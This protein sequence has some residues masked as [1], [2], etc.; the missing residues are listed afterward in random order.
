M[1]RKNR[2]TRGAL[3]ASLLQSCAIIALLATSVDA[4]QKNKKDAVNASPAAA[5][6]LTRTTTK[7]ESRRFGYGSALTL[8]GAP[9]GSIT[10][11]SWTRSEV[12]ITADIEL[13]ADSEEDLTLLSTV[14]GFVL[15]DDVNRVRILTTG[16][17][18]KAFMKR[19]AKGFPKRLLGLPWK[20]DYRIRVPAV[21]DIEIDAG[22]GPITLKGVEGAITLTALESNVTLNLTG[23][24]VRATVGGGTINIGLSARSWRGAGADIQLAAGELTVD[25]PS[26]YS[27][28]INADILRTG[29]IE[30]EY[31][32]LEPR[33]ERTP[34]T[35]RS[36]KGRA[37]AGGPT[38]SFTVG[39][40]TLRIKK[41]TA[42]E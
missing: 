5:A 25:L 12:D 36:I 13:R 27:G 30:N 9:A 31:A 39:D 15:D 3:L 6:K 34:F 29:R 17:H 37:G 18:D 33:E 20:I 1:T 32:G 23:G 24:L 28:D 11:E 2:I 16:T 21:T 7:H 14:N 42:N 19:T 8:L 22:R 38:L 26:G 41:A 10:I 40:G 35:P 4:Q